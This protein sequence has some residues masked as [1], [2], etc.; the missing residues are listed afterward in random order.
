MDIVNNAQGGQFEL[1]EGEHLATLEYSE[2]DGVIDL[3]FV[4]VPPPLR[5]RG[6]A[7]EL[8]RA[9]LEHARAHQLQVIPSCSFVR[10]YLDQHPEYEPLTAP[11]G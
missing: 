9:A 8:A 10:W 5:H 11:P 7:S 3:L 6:L 1:R 4:Q 2:E